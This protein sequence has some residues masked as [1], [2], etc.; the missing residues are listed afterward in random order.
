MPTLRA[1]HWKTIRLE[2]ASTREFPDGS[3]SR[4]FVL[5]LPIRADGSIDE[6]EIQ[7]NPSLATLGRYWAS[8]PD[9]IGQI[10]RTSGSLAFSY[11]REHAADCELP[12]QPISLGGQVLLATSDGRE[13][14]FRVVSIR[15]VR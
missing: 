5:R 3:V 11:G 15:Q 13:L 2:L 9:R 10:V 12:T 8:E 7:R 1:M 14:P 6:A 4:A